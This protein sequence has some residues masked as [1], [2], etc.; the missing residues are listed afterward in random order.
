[1][2][3]LVLVGSAGVGLG[4]LGLRLFQAGLLRLPPC[5]LKTLTGLPCATCGL[6]R[7]ALALGAGD[8]RAAVH[9]HPV[10]SLLLVLLP[11]GMIWDARRAWTDRPYPE[12]PQSPWARGAALGLLLGAWALQAVRGI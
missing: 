6:T 1:M 4:A 5:P 3:W 2:P 7:W 12:L 11:F 8:W 9:W 10:A